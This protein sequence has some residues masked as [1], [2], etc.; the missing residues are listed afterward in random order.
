MVRQPRRRKRRK[1]R[2]RRYR[3]RRAAWRRQDLGG[4]RKP[5]LRVGRWLQRGLGLYGCFGWDHLRVTR[6]GNLFHY[7]HRRAAAEQ[8]LTQRTSQ[9]NNKKG[10]EKTYVDPALNLNFCFLALDVAPSV[11]TAAGFSL[12]GSGAHGDGADPSVTLRS[13]LMD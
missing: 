3:R 11:N 6:R 13:D 9:D 7:C 2:R 10:R 12:V 8:Q 1:M 4:R 5:D